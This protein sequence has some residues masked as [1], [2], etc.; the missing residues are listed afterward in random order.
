[1]TNEL[2]KTTA[3]ENGEVIVSGR[4][5]HEFLEL[6]T[7]YPDWI[8]RMIDYGFEEKV[9]FIEFWSEPNFG[10]AV[11]YLGSHQKMT[12]NGYSIEHALK[13]DMAKEISMI[14]RNEKGKQARQYFIQVEKDYKNKLTVQ[15][16]MIEDPIERAKQWI[17]EQEERQLLMLENTK[18]DQI[19]GELKPKADYTDLVLK[20]EGLMTISQIAKDYGF[21]GAKLNAILNVQG[22]QYKQSG[23]WLLY[24]KYHGKNYTKSNTI[25]ITRNDG[26]P[27]TKL[28][29][30]WTQKG[31]LFIYDLLKSID[32][33]PTI[34]S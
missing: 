5:L 21:S 31:R 4:E 19:I 8:K 1:M 34:E 10:N 22:V 7:K 9:D 17:K 3:N 29:T 6:S 20:S 15:S 18:K 28:N 12:A 24:S 27:D 26:S 2:I 14:Q 33:L 32:I 25:N 30:K 11:E 13:L 16:Y 23:Q